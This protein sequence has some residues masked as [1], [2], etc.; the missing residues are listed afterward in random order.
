MARRVLS[1]CYEECLP[2]STVEFLRDGGCEMT[3]ARAVG[4]ALQLF[5]TAGFDVI[6]IN[7]T[8]SV[9]QEQLFVHL[10]RQKSTIPIVWISEDVP[11]KPTG[12]TV[13]LN[14]SVRPEGLL[15]ILSDL[16]DS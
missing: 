5:E 7:Q 1:V 15:R 14:P 8:V 10:V 3:C 6:L 2:E 9:G 13:C 11:D 4:V 16:A 12:V